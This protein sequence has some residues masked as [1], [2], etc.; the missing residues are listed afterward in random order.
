M[1][2]AMAA[3]YRSYV[4]RV[5]RPVDGGDAVRLDVE[6]LLGGGHVAVVGDEARSLADRL[7][8]MIAG[9]PDVRP[10]RGR[11]AGPP[12]VDQPE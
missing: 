8:T 2:V 12:P 4:I 7:H 6:D 10:L 5:R 3:T 9:T 1:I 11:V